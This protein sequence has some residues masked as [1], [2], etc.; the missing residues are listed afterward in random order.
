[1]L[2]FRSYFDLPHNQNGTVVAFSR[3][4]T[5]LYAQGNSLILAYI[6]G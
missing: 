4:P 1:M 2:G 5:V 6:K 3:R